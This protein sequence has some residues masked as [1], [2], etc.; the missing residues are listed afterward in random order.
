ME[1]LWHSRKG[2]REKATAVLRVIMRGKPKPSLALPSVWL[3][4]DGNVLLHSVSHK[5]PL[6]L[7]LL[8]TSR[9]LT[10]DPPG[11]CVFM[12]LYVSGWAE[13]V[14][15]KRGTGWGGLQAPVSPPTPSHSYSPLWVLALWGCRCWIRRW[16]RGGKLAYLCGILLFS[17]IWIM[18]APSLI[19]SLFFLST[20]SCKH[21]LP[22]HSL[23]FLSVCRSVS[24]PSLCC[25]TLAY[26][27]N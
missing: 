25:L 6:I 15:V 26:H 17:V 16:G 10:I 14:I 27:A 18:I 12:W 22:A 7:D 5:P 20:L 2:G 19:P 11:L 21:R 13:R 3:S 23:V 4:L 24:F 1:E 8:L 9:C